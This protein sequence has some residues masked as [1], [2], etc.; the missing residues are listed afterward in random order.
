VSLQSARAARPTSAP[1]SFFRTLPIPQTWWMAAAA[2]C[3]LW[4]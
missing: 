1:A 4:N 3:W 2:W